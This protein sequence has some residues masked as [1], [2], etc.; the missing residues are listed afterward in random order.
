MSSMFIW[1][2]GGAFHAMNISGAI[3]LLH[4]EKAANMVTVPP[5][6]F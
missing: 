1:G 4:I 5:L 3:E 6:L 2:G